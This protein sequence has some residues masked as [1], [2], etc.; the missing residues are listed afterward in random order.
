[1]RRKAKTGVVAQNIE[2]VTAE[3]LLNELNTEA[4][5]FSLE[6]LEMLKLFLIF[7]TQDEDVVNIVRNG[8][9]DALEAITTS[10]SQRNR[11][12]GILSL[13]I[14]GEREGSLA[15]CRWRMLTV[16]GY[17]DRETSEALLNRVAE[18]LTRD[19]GK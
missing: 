1:M 10:L 18:N 5:A 15:N 3:S 19:Y 12:I 8:Q 17:P 2:T 11:P 13:E 14:V 4:L 9:P 16:W 6:Q 7:A